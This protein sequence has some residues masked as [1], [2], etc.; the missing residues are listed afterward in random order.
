MN[1][2]P[3]IVVSSIAGHD[4]EYGLREAVLA[5]LNKVSAIQNLLFANSFSIALRRQIMIRLIP[6]QASGPSHE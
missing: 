2:R 1:A 5:R 3:G 6:L 4:C